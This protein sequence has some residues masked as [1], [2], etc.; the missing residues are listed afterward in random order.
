M[1]PNLVLPYAVGE[2]SG[3]LLR[4]ASSVGS[5]ELVEEL[6]AAQVHAREADY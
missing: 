1:P 3:A 2:G 6:L 5:V 4:V